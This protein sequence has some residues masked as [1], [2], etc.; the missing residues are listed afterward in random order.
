MKNEIYIPDCCKPVCNLDFLQCYKTL[1]DLDN[2]SMGMAI[3]QVREEFRISQ[4]KLA[5]LSNINQAYFSGVENGKY[6]ISHHK[7]ACLCR[8]LD[9]PIEELTKITTHEFKKLVGCAEKF[10]FEDDKGEYY[11]VEEIMNVPRSK[12]LNHNHKLIK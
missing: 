8:T 2:L 9:L 1:K 6:S 7:L 10:I 12:N 5:L 11:V 3:K 4:T